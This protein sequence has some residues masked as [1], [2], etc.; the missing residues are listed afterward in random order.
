MTQSIDLEIRDGMDI[1]HCVLL[2]EIVCADLD[3]YPGYAGK[4]RSIQRINLNNSSK[5]SIAWVN[6][7]RDIEWLKSLYKLNFKYAVIWHD[8]SW[9]SDS[10]FENELLKTIQED[11]NKHEVPWIAAGHIIDYSESSKRRYPEWHHQCTVINIEEWHKSGAEHP[12]NFRKNREPFI[13]SE[14]KMHGDYTP[15]WLKPDSDVSEER[16]IQLEKMKM[17]FSKWNGF[18]NLS[19]AKGCMVHNLPFSVRNE[20]HCC[21]P[22][23]DIEETMEWLL[24]LDFIDK[25]N[26]EDIVRLS[27]T[28]P[29]DKKEIWGFKVQ[30][31]FILYITNTEGVP[32]D[33]VIAPFTTMC[34]P[35]S[36]LHQ[37]KHIALNLDTMKKV[38]WFDYNPYAL[39][40]TKMVLDEWDG[41]DFRQFVEKNLP[42]VLKDKLLRSNNIIFDPELVDEFIESFGGEDAWVEVFNNIKQLE[43]VFLEVD[44]IKENDKLINAVGKNQTVFINVTNIWQYESNYLNNAQFAPQASYIN[45]L[46]NLL[47]NNKDVYVSGDTPGGVFLD[48]KNVKL[49]SEIK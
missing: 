17:D 41:R 8:G 36:G 40:W 42:R 43:H 2:D 16:E 30:K 5:Q 46:K 10:D 13:A 37:F 7:Q 38:V 32:F 29:S 4:L 22:E 34:V 6:W 44:M 11:W 26:E 25:Y 14:E 21:Y 15:I 45:L 1:I 18:I 12:K 19:L 48:Y 23:D 24:D 39:A 27:K 20:K 33:K 9:P 31:Y 28:I 49:L 35:C 47:L 3:K